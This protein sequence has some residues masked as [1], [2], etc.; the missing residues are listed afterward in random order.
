MGWFLTNFDLAAE[1]VGGT[2]LH[3]SAGTK[4]QL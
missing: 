4:E 2:T 1:C 3:K